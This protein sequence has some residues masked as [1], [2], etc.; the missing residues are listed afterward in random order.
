MKTNLPQPKKYNQKTCFGA[1]IAAHARQILACSP[2][3]CG[4]MPQKANFSTYNCSFL[5]KKIDRKEREI[6]P[7]INYIILGTDHARLLGNRV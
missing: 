2:R 4:E 1:K 3:L 6:N 7:L 5:N